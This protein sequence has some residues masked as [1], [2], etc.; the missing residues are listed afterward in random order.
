MEPADALSLPPPR[1][2]HARWVNMS[3]EILKVINSIP[4]LALS[5]IVI[6]C[7]PIMAA[8][9]YGELEK[10]RNDVTALHEDV[11]YD[12][13]AIDKFV[14]LMIQSQLSANDACTLPTSKQAKK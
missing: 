7:V 4:L 5:R 8:T 9:G 12:H 11:L 2:T 10:L 1:I 6:V 14:N 3:E 13:A